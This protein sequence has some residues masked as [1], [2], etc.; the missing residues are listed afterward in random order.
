MP[1]VAVPVSGR[2][3]AAARAVVV[4]LLV[5]ARALALLA[6]ED[7]GAEDDDLHHDADEG[8]ERGVLVL[9]ADE[10]HAH[11]LKHVAVLAGLAH[12]AAV[13]GPGIKEKKKILVIH[14]L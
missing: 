2:A 14:G 7:D 5:V 6:D 9:D 4:V 11:V 13:V 12:F 10:G 1:E 3:G 8:V